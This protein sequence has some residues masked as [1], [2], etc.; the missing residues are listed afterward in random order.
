MKDWLR[1]LSPGRAL[2]GLMSAHRL[3]TVGGIILFILA[4]FS[5]IGPF[6]SPFGRDEVNIAEIQAPPGNGHIL[7]TDDLGRDIFVRLAYGGRVSLSVGI[8]AML[9]Q[10]VIGVVLGSVAGFY[11]GIY[12]SVIM[13]LTDVVMCFPF[14]V[15]SL[16]VAALT[17][18]SFRNVILIIGLLGWPAMARVVRGSILGL[19]NTE[20]IDAARAL[21]LT[22]GEIIFRHLLPNS[23]GP[24]IVYGTLNIAYAVMIEASLSFLGLGIAQPQPSWGTMLS[25]AQKLSILQRCSWMWIPPGLM[26][27]LTV[28]SINFIG[29]GIS[30]IFH[31]TGRGSA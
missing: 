5:L 23:V 7:G 30:E 29:E 27:F 15:I 13:R 9:I 20:F 11:G 18:P 25:A 8:I 17:G 1:K 3:V 16:S 31:S 4:I 10:V 12:D 14:F 19:K 24:I 2:L 22:Q 6:F 28:M 26:V 21:G